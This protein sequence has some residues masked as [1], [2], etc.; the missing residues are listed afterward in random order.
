M[1]RLYYEAGLVSINYIKQNLHMHYMFLLVRQ[2]PN[3][4]DLAIFATYHPVLRIK[5][6]R[7]HD[8]SEVDDRYNDCKCVEK[9]AEMLF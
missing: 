1:V 9:Q 7:Y 3:T 5:W 4:W 2:F 6:S 8:E